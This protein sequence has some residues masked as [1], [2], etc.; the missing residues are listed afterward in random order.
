MTLNTPQKS[1]TT[2]DSPVAQAS[3]MRA[4]ELKTSADK[5]QQA[6]KR[7]LAFEE[8][9]RELRRA[10]LKALQRLGRVGVSETD[11]TLQIHTLGT[12]DV[13]LEESAK[14]TRKALDEYEAIMKESLKREAE[15]REVVRKLKEAAGR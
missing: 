12:L 5:E 2:N 8:E 6:L 15:T 1:S 4:A 7:Y 3:L 11:H 9:H 13:E 14:N 10:V